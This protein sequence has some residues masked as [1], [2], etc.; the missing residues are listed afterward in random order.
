MPMGRTGFAGL[1][2]NITQ[3][4]EIIFRISYS[5]LKLLQWGISKTNFF[6]PGYKLFSKL[7]NI[8]AFFILE[9]KEIVIPKNEFED[10]VIQSDSEGI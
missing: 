9:I 1:R 3:L 4:S 7:Q 6:S 10:N 8:G 5:V 2:L